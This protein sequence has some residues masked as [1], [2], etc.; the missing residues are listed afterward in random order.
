LSPK[1]NNY[2]TQTIPV[3]TKIFTAKNIVILEAIKLANSLRAAN[4]LNISDFLNVLTALK[5][6]WPHIV[7]A[8]NTQ[9]ELIDTHK[10]IPNIEFMWI[11][12]HIGIKGNEIVDE[13]AN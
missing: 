8:Q 6:Q 7:I 13:A 11:P 1:P 9:T 10:N 4:I 12:S 5:N 3:I 2:P